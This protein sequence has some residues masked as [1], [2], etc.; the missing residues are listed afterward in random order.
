MDIDKSGAGSETGDSSSAADTGA[1]V[2]SWH[3][4]DRP[5]SEMWMQGV[6]PEEIAGKLGR[7][8]AAVMTRVSRLGLPR[9]AAPGRK[10]GVRYEKSGGV[11]RRMAINDGKGIKKDARSIKSISDVAV[12]AMS[13]VKA[14]GR[15]AG[16]TIPHISPDVSERVCLMCLSKFMSAGKHNRICSR[17]KDTSEYMMG[18]SLPEAGLERVL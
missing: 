6:S 2:S 15:P 7:S 4:Q 3:E 13:A 11:R 9:R 5:L 17:C 14:R 1:S 18:S 8:V 12:A 10:P 16:A